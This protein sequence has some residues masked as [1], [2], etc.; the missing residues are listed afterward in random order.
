MEHGCPGGS[1]R[2]HHAAL[3]RRTI[4]G[5]PTSTNSFSSSHACTSDASPFPHVLIPVGSVEPCGCWLPSCRDPSS[6][7]ASTSLPRVPRRRFYPLLASPPKAPA[8]GR[9]RSIRAGGAAGARLLLPDARRADAR[10]QRGEKGRRK[11]E[12]NRIFSPLPVRADPTLTMFRVVQEKPTTTTVV[13]TSPRFRGV[14]PPPGACLLLRL[15]PTA[16]GSTSGETGLITPGEVAVRQRHTDRPP[17]RHCI[18]SGT[19]HV[20]RPCCVY[21]IWM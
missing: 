12:Q 21:R 20:T 3:A 5:F 15:G 14:P 2:H 7:P 8:G 6:A 19:A 4:S 18:I 1:S 9:K 17:P 10:C 16:V 13:S 11:S